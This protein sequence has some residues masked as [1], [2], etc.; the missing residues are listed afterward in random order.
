MNTPR[1]ADDK[2]FI[3]VP[4]P[5]V[6]FGPD[7]ISADEADAEYLREAARKLDQHYKPF[8]S[9]LR[10]TVVKLLQDSADSIEGSTGEADDDNALPVAS[11]DD[12]NRVFEQH[13]QHGDREQLMDELLSYSYSTGDI[14][15]G[16]YD[17]YVQGSWDKIR[18]AYINE[19]L[20]DAEYYVLQDHY[21]G[22]E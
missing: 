20:T 22:E 19:L 9:N 17:S 18:E 12:V 13:C 7:G 5:H 15:E 10:T 1:N 2:Q 3:T 4:R 16:L 6:P 11:I 8:G 14:L 21:Y